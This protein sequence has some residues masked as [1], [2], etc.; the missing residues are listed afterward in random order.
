MPDSKEASSL[1]FSETR[2]TD[3]SSL[4]QVSDDLAHQAPI[5][6]KQSGDHSGSARLHA[7]NRVRFSHNFNEFHKL[8]RA[9][10][11]RIQFAFF[12]KQAGNGG[13]HFKT[14]QPRLSKFW[15]LHRR[16]AK[17]LTFSLQTS[18]YKASTSGPEDR[19][20]TPHQKLAIR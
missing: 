13:P 8:R 2:Y 14:I 20:A 16:V 5:R 17:P 7:R 18:G 15:V 11:R 12:G 9:D 10:Q 3:G 1:R 19:L 4:N 6:D